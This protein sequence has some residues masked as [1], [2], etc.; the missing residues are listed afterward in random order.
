MASSRPAGIALEAGEI[1]LH[2]PVPQ[3]GGDLVLHQLHH[4][5]GQRLAVNRDWDRWMRGCLRRPALPALPWPLAELGR[6]LFLAPPGLIGDDGTPRATRTIVNVAVA[7]YC[8]IPRDLMLRLLLA[9]RYGIGKPAQL[10]LICVWVGTTHQNPS[11]LGGR[12]LPYAGY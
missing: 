1:A 4:A 7:E 8:E 11:C 2:A 3:R 9:R 10:A 12:C 6:S 5:R